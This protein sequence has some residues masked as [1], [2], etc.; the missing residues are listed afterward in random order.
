M[1]RSGLIVLLAGLALLPGCEKIARNMYDQPR[2][3]PMRES[4]LFP[5]GTS[6][7]APVPGTV[8]A[9]SGNLSG[10]SSGRIG[11]KQEARRARDEKAK[12]NPYPVTM[13][14]LRRGRE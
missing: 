7:R 2:Y 5:D 8:A 10:T 13:Q 3:K 1:G 6:A 4:P 11:A 9:A 14:L 12:D